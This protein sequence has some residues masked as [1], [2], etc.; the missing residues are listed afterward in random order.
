MFELVSIIGLIIALT[1]HEFSHAFVADRLGDPTPAANGRLSLNPLH[2]LDPLGTIMLLVVHLG[3]AKPVPIDP[4]NLSHPRRDEFLIALA[5][6]ASNLLLATVL[7]GLLHLFPQFISIGYVIVAVNVS[8][9]VFNLIP[10]APLDGSKVLSNLLPA[11]SSSTFDQIMDRFSLP[12]L[13][14]ALIIP[15]NGSNLITILLT[16]PVNFILQLLFSGV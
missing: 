13:I 5:G 10:I 4:Y 15:I 1:I 2:H 12:L 3:W 8:L 11:D 9:A 6:P 7:A 16:P 14:L